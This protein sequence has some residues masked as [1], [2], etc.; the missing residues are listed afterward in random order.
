MKRRSF[1]ERSIAAV[2]ASRDAALRH[3]RVG[4]NFIELIDPRVRLVVLVVLIVAAALSRQLLAI[5]VLLGVTTLVGLFAGMSPRT[6]LV[7]VWLPALLFSGVIAIPALFTTRGTPL[8]RVTDRLTVTETGA[9]TAAFLLL[10]V[11]TAVT[12]TYV[13]IASTRWSRVLAALRS[14][15]IPAVVIAIFEMTHRYLFVLLDTA[16]EML[17][18][19]RSRT[20]GP[21]P[22][23][24]RR[25]VT[26]SVAGALLSR[27]IATSAEVHAA[28][29]ARGFRGEVRTL[30]EFRLGAAD[31]TFLT[32]ACAAAIA[33]A[34]RWSA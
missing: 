21:L 18:S 25:R 14:L 24:E 29:L 5:A 32:F 6:L 15:R 10:R 30:D 12:L 19:R 4:A 23:S 8:L 27:S 34:W 26:T 20:V 11:I 7:R 16:H 9:R 22:S 33:V 2:A 31:L 28:M 13:L 1:L 3:D 17:Q